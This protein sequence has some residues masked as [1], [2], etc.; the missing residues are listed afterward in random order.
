MTGRSNY[1]YRLILVDA[2]S[3]ETL[4]KIN[5]NGPSHTPRVGEQFEFKGVTYSVD[6]VT[7]KMEKFAAHTPTQY[8]HKAIVRLEP[9]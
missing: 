2:S 9:I 3:D 7:N 1:R 4:E 8:S 5:P 6:E